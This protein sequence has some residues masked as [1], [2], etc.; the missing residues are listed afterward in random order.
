MDGTDRHIDADAAARAYFAS[1]PTRR[2]VSNVILLDPSGQR[3]ALVKP[4]YRDGWLLPGGT[5]DDGESPWAAAHREVRE[6]LGLEVPLDGLAVVQWVPASGFVTEAI[7]FVFHGPRLTDD[8]VAG[9][10]LPPGELDD[11]RFCDLDD[12][13]ELSPEMQRSRLEAAWHATRG[14]QPILLG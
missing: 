6:E 1:V 4:T 7:H 8:E 10:V 12:A 5:V 3:L 14:A 9:I 11:V 13:L 2:S